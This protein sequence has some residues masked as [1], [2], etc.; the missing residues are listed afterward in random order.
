MRSKARCRRATSSTSAVGQRGAAAA[1]AEVDALHGVDELLQRREAPAQEPAVDEHH[2]Q[3]RGDEHE[4]ALAL[5]ERVG[6]QAGRRRDRGED[7]R[8]DRAAR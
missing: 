1:A 4:E 6:V 8:G 7:R 3:Q 2:G 5:D